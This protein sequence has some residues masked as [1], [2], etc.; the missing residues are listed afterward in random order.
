MRSPSPS[1]TPGLLRVVERVVILAPEGFTPL[2]LV[3]GIGSAAAVG[4]VSPAQAGAQ[5]ENSSNDYDEF[6]DCGH[7]REA[8]WV[9]DANSDGQ[10][11]P[12][13]AEF[14]C[15]YLPNC[16]AALPLVGI[17]QDLIIGEHAT[18]E[19][20]DDL[21]RSDVTFCRGDSWPSFEDFLESR[22]WVDEF[23]E[24]Y[25]DWIRDWLRDNSVAYRDIGWARRFIRDHGAVE[26]DAVA[27]PDDSTT[28]PDTTPT[29]DPDNSTDDSPESE[30]APEQE[31]V[32]PD[33]ADTTEQEVVPEAGDS[34]ESEEAPGQ[35]PVDPDPADTTEQEPVP[36]A[37]DSSESEEA[38]GQEPV[39]PDP[40]DTTEQQ[41]V[42]DADSGAQTALDTTRPR[43]TDDLSEPEETPQRESTDPGS[44]T[45]ALSEGLVASSTTEAMAAQETS[46][47]PAGSDG[48]LPELIAIGAGSALVVAALGAYLARRRRRRALWE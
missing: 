23:F 33:P 41:A 16:S 14:H 42:P 5:G 20:L 9:S 17:G 6:I 47:M 3:V 48:Y 10:P 45:S 38:P 7:G 18:R 4:V 15:G 2:R 13:S 35:E 30:E 21:Y 22:P 27:E 29:Q 44:A 31:P 12:S 34:P 24:E 46:H 43:T 8:E 39:D 26:Q 11:G 32:D 36:E 1:A 40:A 28:T 37:G 25:S 19:Q